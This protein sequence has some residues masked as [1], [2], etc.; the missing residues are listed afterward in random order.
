MVTLDTLNREV[1]GPAPERAIDEEVKPQ[2]FSKKRTIVLGAL[3]G[4]QCGL[5]VVIR[6]PV[7]QTRANGV[8]DQEMIVLI[9]KRNVRKGQWSGEAHSALKDPAPQT[10]HCFNAL[11]L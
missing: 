2:L 11:L 10:L 8:L 9:G 7:K 3:D 5:Q 1:K 4:C 6:Q